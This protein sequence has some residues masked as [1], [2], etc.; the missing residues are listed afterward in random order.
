VTFETVKVVKPIRQLKAD[1]AYIL[2]HVVEAYKDKKTI[3]SAFRDEV[4]SQLADDPGLKEG[5]DLIIETKARPF[6]FDELLGALLR[7][8][9]H[10]SRLGS[11]VFINVSAGSSEFAAA[12]TVAAMM[13]P[14]TKAF[15]VAVRDYM[16]TG[17]ER[18]KEVYFDG[19]RPV[20]QARDIYEPRQMPTFTID[21]PPEDLVRGLRLL[22]A[23]MRDRKLITYAEMIC[24]L[25][26]A[27]F[28][29]PGV[30]AEER[31]SEGSG[32][33]ARATATASDKMRYRRY[34]LEGWERMCWIE[35]DGS[36]GR[37]RITEAGENVL[38]MFY[39]D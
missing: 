37:V 3:Y 26:E 16:V 39:L 15:T 28:W 20:G 1:R 6:R 5:K 11:E 7:I 22:H 18:I 32:K 4:I 24:D 8:L 19:D 29:K 36:G 10:E 38:D 9:S 25:K 23:R 33:R 34:F 21:M 14:G 2:F 35:R 27:G 30:P 31:S 17:E 13:V 12:A